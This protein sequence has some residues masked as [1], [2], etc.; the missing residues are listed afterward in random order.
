M[1]LKRRLMFL[2]VAL[3]LR[4]RETLSNNGSCTGINSNWARSLRTTA[5]FP[6]KTGTTVEVEC[7]YT[8]A[9]NEGSNVITCISGEDYDFIKEPTCMIAGW[10][11]TGTRQGR[12]DFDLEYS[13]LQ[14]LTDSVVGSEDEI[15]I[16]I[17]TFEKQDES[18][19]LYCN[20]VKVNEFNYM[21]SVSDN[22][23]CKEMW[24]YDFA[25]V[26]FVGYD[27]LD[28]ASDYMRQYKEVRCTSLK[29]EWASTLKTTT[30]FPVELGTEVEVTCSNSGATNQGSSTVTCRGITGTD[31]T[32][33]AEPI[34][35][36][37]I[38]N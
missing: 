30:D 24:S 19:H 37:L 1:K 7:F 34:C 16:R 26:K 28:N 5:Q 11:L 18:L 31:F 8:E 2:I 27:N 17:W 6:V 15:L 22:D 38:A 10:E 4:V 25:H 21:E 29:T 32:F 13:P 20:D 35:S 14:I 23:E 33:V 36:G 12:I 3:I 9:I